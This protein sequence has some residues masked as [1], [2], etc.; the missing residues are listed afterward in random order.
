M[1]DRPTP[2]ELRQRLAA[3]RTERPFLTYRDAAGAQQIYTLG[4]DHGD[5]VAIGR[6]DGC[7]IRLLNDYEISRLH[8]QLQ[9]IGGDWVIADDGLS[10]NGTFVNDER[11][12]LRHRLRD[13]DV[14]RCGCTRLR[15][16]TAGA[17][18]HERTAPGTD[19]VPVTLTDTQRRLLVALCRPLVNGDPFALPTSNQAISDEIHLSI[20]GVKAHLRTLFRK[21]DVDDDLAHNHKRLRLAERAV[22]SGVINVRELLADP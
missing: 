14:I 13:G 5:Q 1:T 16:S 19:A 4:G 15:F 6:G 2:E 21:L 9:R 7:E 20:G 22:E 10:R 3:E 18:P 17:R 8:A 12:A 11:L